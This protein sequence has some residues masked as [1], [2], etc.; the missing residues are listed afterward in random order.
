MPIVDS[1]KCQE[2]RDLRKVCTRGF[3]LLLFFVA[4]QFVELFI[5]PIDFFT[6]RVWEAALA[7]PYR[8]PGMFYPNIYVKKNK[9]YGDRY[10]SDDPAQIK[11]RPVEWFTDSY[12]YR[13]RPE[14]ERRPKYD[15]VVLGDSNI[16]GS[17]LDQKDTLTEVMAARSNNTVYSYSIGHDHISLFFNDKRVLKKSPD[18][19]VVESKVGN[20]NTNDSYLF[21]FKEAPDGSL[22]IIDRTAEIERYYAPNR[23][24]FF[25]K[26]ESRL[27]KQAM[28]HWLQASLATYFSIP[29]ADKAQLFFG[30][31]RAP[32]VDATGWR[33]YGWI[34]SSGAFKPLVNGL[35][36]ALA[37]RATGP[38]AY[39]HTERF[40]SVKPDGKVIVRFQAKNSITPSRHRIYIFEN[41]SYRSLGEIVTGSE[42]GTFEIPLAS[43]PGSILEF[44]IDQND[45]WQWLS[46]KDVE[47][48]GG[49]YPA[50]I[51]KSPI[52]ISM[53]N[54]Q[55]GGACQGAIKRVQDCREWPV[56]KNGYIQ[57][58]TLPPSGSAG[59]QLRFEAR[60]DTPTQ[61]FS[62][63]YLFEG[64]QYRKVG[65]YSFDAQWR[66]YSLLVQSDMK[67]TTKIQID[68]PASVQKLAI[69]NFRVTPA[70]RLDK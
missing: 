64:T 40:T 16:V 46:L 2:I 61:N 19:V 3:L 7:S 5:L 58:P 13:N 48:I 18:L 67:A 10:R 29:S 21:N 52:S 60:T 56:V 27:K 34:V 55:G 68:F 36:P 22:E 11:A 8:Y 44:Q 35:E 12:G 69:R 30:S 50:S 49:G 66:E 26:T 6:F 15:A 43:S 59:M 4:L 63:I 41:G 51:K 28:F 23:N 9:E 37:V 33:P 24:L 54:W 42:W 62:S 20:W 57:T 31:S 14:I 17:S 1:I 47:V 25:E 70:D 32:V 65:E 39:W 53:L 38:N 45:D